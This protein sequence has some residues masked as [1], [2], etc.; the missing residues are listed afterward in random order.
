MKIAGGV[1][2]ESGGVGAAG[3]ASSYCA[4]TRENVACSEV[5]CHVIQLLRS[6]PSNSLQGRPIRQHPPLAPLPI[7]CPPPIPSPPP[8]SAP[9]H[10]ALA[11]NCLPGRPACSEAPMYADRPTPWAR[12]SGIRLLPVPDR[13]SQRSQDCEQ[14]S[15]GTYYDAGIGVQGRDEIPAASWANGG[16]G[17]IRIPGTAI[18]LRWLRSFPRALLTFNRLPGN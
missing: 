8:S 1:E 12:S 16:T 9:L 13:R 15:C 11:F 3:R 5:I 14:R 4:A 18:Q 7:N 2:P 6:G 10:D 17:E